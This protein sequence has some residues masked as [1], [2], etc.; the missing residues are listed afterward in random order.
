[1]FSP[2]RN[3]LSR[4]SDLPVTHTAGITLLIVEDESIVALDLQARLVRMGYHVCSRAVSGKESIEQAILHRPDLILMDIRL[5]G[6][7]DGIQAAQQIQNVL[8]IPIIY[9]TAY[10]DIDT[11]RRA[12]VTEPHGYLIKPFEE[13]ELYIAIEL[14]LHKYAMERRSKQQARQL[15]QIV[16]SI[17]EGVA[18]L[19]S[20]QNILLANPRAHLLLSLAF[21]E[22]IFEGRSNRLWSEQLQK[23]I[24]APDEFHEISVERKP[25]LIFE[26]MGRS[27]GDHDR[28]SAPQW[29]LIVRDVTEER[30]QLARVRQQAHLAGLGRL[31]AGI[32]HDF[33][34]ILAII[35]TAEQIIM[36]TQSDLTVQNRKFLTAN[37]E[38]V[39]RGS[40]LVKQL[41]DFGRRAPNE[42]EPMDLARLLRELV[43]S[44]RLMVPENIALEVN[45]PEQPHVVTADPANMQQVVINLI[46]NAR[47]AMPN[48]GALEIT[49][50]IVSVPPGDARAELQPGEWVHLSIADNGEGIPP[51]ILPH[52]FEPFFT[53][54]PFGQGSGLGLAQVY[55]IVQQYEGHIIASRREDQQTVFDVYFP[56]VDAPDGG[57][58]PAQFATDR[59]WTGRQETVL[60]VEDEARLREPVRVA[61][62]L[63]NFRVIEAS[64]GREALTICEGNA[65]IRLIISDVVMPE[66]GGV[67]FFR[68]LKAR[69]PD[70]PVIIMSG[71]SSLKT[72]TELIGLGV[73]EYLRKPVTVD[74]LAK[75]IQ[76]TLPNR[77]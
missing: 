18:L 51:Q 40:A 47:D 53:T 19:D 60:L 74:D 32:A 8:S 36:M 23:V 58:A 46:T 42:P 35:S 61:L 33:N 22:S 65:D 59:D 71:H 63:L 43:T 75:S 45:I 29:L 24:D 48:G 44:I 56:T 9:L 28:L 64:N 72:A 68:L 7:M 70:I 37:Q 6:G 1:M 14:A 16:N 12:Q 27:V 34:N 20:E 41:M 31:A 11:L 38:Q 54:K 17:P 26:I 2:V 21:D 66:M 10:A 57:A 55:G 67:E 25:A 76:R 13:R 73:K 4:A 39:R 77:H 52:I 62:E 5:R 49:L 3:E 30:L 69:N 15:E 50:D